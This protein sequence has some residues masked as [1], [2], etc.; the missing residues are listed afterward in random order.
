[1]ING[2][3]VIECGVKR[4]TMPHIVPFQAAW[5]VKDNWS[6][7]SINLTHKKGTAQPTP[8]LKL[9]FIIKYKAG[10]YRSVMQGLDIRRRSTEVQ[11]GGQ[12]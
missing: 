4:L 10:S 3:Q 8:H 12:G 5:D 11:Q 1:M 9:L 2:V 7:S 6:S